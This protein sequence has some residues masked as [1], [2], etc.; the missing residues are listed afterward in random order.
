MLLK[1]QKVPV[2]TPEFNRDSPNLHEAFKLFKEQVTYLLIKGPRKNLEDDGKI[3]AFLNWH[4]PKS[5]TV[6]NN[7]GLWCGEI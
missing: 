4:G 3:G 6:F 1:V 7:L 5:Y 2:Q